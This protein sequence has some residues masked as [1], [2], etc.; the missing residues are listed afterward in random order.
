METYYLKDLLFA[1]KKNLLI[2]RDN[3]E[4]F[5][6]YAA[7]YAQKGLRLSQEMEAELAG[8]PQ[9]EREALIGMVR[10]YESEFA[11]IISQ[12]RAMGLEIDENV[13]F[14]T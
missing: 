3:P 13:E 10:D 9:E 2:A 7:S 8:M 5:G 6:K 11:K 12:V 14:I 4:I 1:A